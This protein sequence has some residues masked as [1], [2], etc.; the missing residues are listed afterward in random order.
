[1]SNLNK[2]IRPERQSNVN[3]PDSTPKSIVGHISMDDMGSNVQKE[4][5]KLNNNPSIGTTAKS[6]SS[7]KPLFEP[8]TLS[9]IE[10]LSYRPTTEENAEVLNQIMMEIYK[11]LT[12]S[13]HD[14]IVSAT[15]VILE[16]LKSDIDVSEKRKGDRSAS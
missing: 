2:L 3:E 5:H 16:I 4:S 6:N 14:T 15:D 9:S 12:D 8:S 11:K 10:D 1:M 7:S 13:S